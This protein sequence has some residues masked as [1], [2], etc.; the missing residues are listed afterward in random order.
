LPAQQLADLQNRAVRLAR[1]QERA[2]VIDRRLLA[3]ARLSQFFHRMNTTKARLAGKSRACGFYRLDAPPASAAVTHDR[4]ML[5]R[6]RRS[7]ARLGGLADA[8]L[9]AG[10]A[11]I[12]RRS[13]KNIG[14]I[15]RKY[16]AFCN[17]KLTRGVQP[18]AVP[19]RSF[20]P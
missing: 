3:S 18:G 7:G 8:E 4:R 5:I 2:S 20:C 16:S 14:I 13:N 12:V 6:R 10:W 1:D 17:R 19:C 15:C 11:S 9:V